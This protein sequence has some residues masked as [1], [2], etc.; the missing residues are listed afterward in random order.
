MFSAAMVRAGIATPTQT[1]ERD[2]GTFGNRSVGPLLQSPHRPVLA[3]TRI[4]L[5]GLLQGCILSRQ[6]LGKHR[7]G[8]GV[9]RTHA[10]AVLRRFLGHDDAK[11]ITMRALLRPAL[12]GQGT[13]NGVRQAS[14][15]S[16]V[17]SDM[18][19]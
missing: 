12:G 8:G 19:A 18:G 3:Q 17:C 6:Q 11:R 13:E 1:S 7:D 5:Q 9:N 4:R 14:G 10:I 15:G 2:A 16:P